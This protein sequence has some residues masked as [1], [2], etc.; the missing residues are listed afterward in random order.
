MHFCNYHF[1]NELCFLAILRRDPYP[2]VKKQG[3]ETVQS[4]VKTSRSKHFSCIISFDNVTCADS[5]KVN[6]S[7]IWCKTEPFFSSAIQLDRVSG[8]DE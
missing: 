6:G 5:H 7:S 4:N 2:V 8:S 1:F 3:L